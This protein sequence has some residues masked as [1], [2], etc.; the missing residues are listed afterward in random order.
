MRYRAFVVVF[1]LL[2]LQSSPMLW[3][4]FVNAPRSQTA[5]GLQG[6]SN[7]SYP[8]LL[9]PPGLSRANAHRS[10]KPS[11]IRSRH[12][13]VRK[14]LLS[15]LSTRQRG[16]LRF[17]LFDD[18]AFDAV[19]TKRIKR[20]ASSYTWFGD[21]VSEESGSFTLAVEKDVVIANIRVPGRGCY[22]IRY[23]SG[24]LHEVREIDANSYF[25]CGGEMQMYESQDLHTTA[26]FAGPIVPM[27]TGSQV[28]VMAVYTPASRSAEGGTVAMDALI[29]LAID[30]ANQAYINSQINLSIRLVYKGEVD[31]TESGS[32]ST[33]LDRLTNISDGHMDSVHDIRDTVGA[34]MVCLFAE[35]TDYGGIAWLM[36]F[37]TS[38]FKSYAFSVVR[39]LQAVGT[40]D[41]FAHELGHNMGCAH[42][43]GDGNPPSIRGEG[44]YGYSHGWRFD[45]DGD[46]EYRTVMAYSPGQNIRY[47]SNPDV[48]YDGQPTG[49]ENLEDNTR[50]INNAAYTVANWRQA[51]DAAPVA[52]DD[53]LTARPAKEIAIQLQAFDEGIPEPLVYIITSL[54]GSGSMADPDNGI[55]TTTPYTLLNNGNEVLYQ[56]DIAYR[57]PETF[58]FKVN[59]G[60]SPPDGGDSNVATVSIDMVEYFTELFDTN[61]LD[62]DNRMLTFIPNDSNDSYLLC[63]SNAE[64]FATDPADA[65][66]LVLGDD[67]YLAVNLAQGKEVS[68]YGNTYSSFYLGSNGY[69][70]FDSGDSN[71]VE[72]LPDH[73]SQK[74]VSAL[75][76]DL[77]PSAAGRVSS[78][79]LADRIAL[80]FENVPEYSVANSNSF[81]IEMFFDGVIRVT[82]LNIDAERG[83]VG[84]SEGMGLGADFIEDNLSHFNVC[85]DFD[86]DYDVNIT[87]LIIFAQYWMDEFCSDSMLCSR[88]DCDRSNRLDLEDL[89]CFGGYWQML[90][91]PNP[92]EQQTFSSI[93]TY[94]GRVWG[95]ADGGLGSNN[96]D[97]GGGA[98][99]LGG[100]QAQQYAY[101]FIVSFDTSELPDT[102]TIISA[103]L[104]LT[105]GV[106]EDETGEDPFNWGGVCYVDIANPYFGS[107][108]T[109]NSSDWDAAPTAGSVAFFTG[110]D[111]GAD[112]KLL[113]GN[114]NSAGISNIGTGPGSTVQMRVRFTNLYDIGEDYLGFY[115]GEH[116]AEPDYQPKLIIE[117]SPQKTTCELSG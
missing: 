111:P 66:T 42:A 68:I 104:E 106:L 107:G 73:F 15:K 110:P 94:D 6:G 13:Q 81:Q 19:F 61:D 43:V 53:E 86:Q 59:D 65:D 71:S 37:L 115:S 49:N 29:N 51:A 17:N 93:G 60:G 1:A 103:Q 40:S 113:S 79:Q 114:F 97:S 23:S 7:L 112:G 30:E 117:Y 101:G 84:L 39:R 32:A 98:L 50:S 36:D 8:D 83:V 78:K 3:A 72:S 116:T 63:I 92:P 22:Q 91:S 74:R 9:T 16:G 4:R 95:R 89:A 69:I 26:G 12:G 62:L 24:Q 10:S 64:R 58:T 20:S 87:D 41:T 28:D 11:V 88:A 2:V 85:A 35:L 45:G 48:F 46:T 47:F 57:G 27:D 34:D 102:I 5:R 33:D 44:L 77:D 54:P 25:A 75:F 21:I 76:C 38:T 96:N 14:D 80:T 56:S 108:I 105:R 82:Y 55:I 70:T 52:Q 67:D 99:L 90:T 31:Y 100:K 18:A 109:L